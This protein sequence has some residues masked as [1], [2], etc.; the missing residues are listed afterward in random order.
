[1]AP[2]VADLGGSGRGGAVVGEPGLGIEGAGGGRCQAEEEVAGGGVDLGCAGGG[3]AAGPG[4][5]GGQG[6]AAGGAGDGG[7]VLQRRV[8]AVGRGPAEVGGPVAA[9]AQGPEDRA[10][11]RRPAHRP[12][13]ATA[14]PAAV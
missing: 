7:G 1:M 3:A 9:R 2:A 8:A 12:G 4:G 11:S 10:G 14:G 6:V 5:E 13:P